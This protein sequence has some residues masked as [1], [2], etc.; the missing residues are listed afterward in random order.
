MSSSH[1]AFLS[2]L[3]AADR[4]VGISGTGFITDPVIRARIGAGDIA[5]VGWDGNFDLERIA[6]IRPDL[7]LFSRSEEA[8]RLVEM[9]LRCEEIGDWRETT[10]L[11]RAGWIITI[12]DLCGLGEEGRER[13]AA[14]EAAYGELAT[15]ARGFSE[16]PR[17]MLNAPYRDVWWVPSDDNFMVQLVRD[18]GGEWIFEGWHS[19]GE[20]GIPARESYPVDIEQAWVA[21]QNADVWLNVGGYESLSGLL[22]DNPRFAQAPPVL[23]GRVFNNTARITPQGGSDF[24]ESGVVRPDR[25]LRDLVGILHDTGDTLYY[26]KRME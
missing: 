1:V 22:A 20:T 24:W 11:G 8:G 21:M 18:A 13:F 10:P 3:G 26:Y 5:E 16:K 9:G 19:S 25:V 7:V 14:I 15:K 23:A 6:A 2:E 4:I 17:V 12:A